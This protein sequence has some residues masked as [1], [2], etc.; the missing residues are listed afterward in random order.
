M[1]GAEIRERFLKYFA[2]KGHKVLPGSSLVPADPTVLLTLA[3]MLQFKPI[4]LGQEKPKYKRVATVQKCVRTIDIEQV[5]KTARH[6]TFF[7]MLGNFSFGDYFKKEAIEYAWELL[8]DEFKLPKEKLLIA[9]YEKDDEAYDLWH[10]TMGVPA[11]KIFRLD[12]ENNFWA[13]GPTGPCGPC[14]EIYY[15]QGADKGCGRPDCAPGCDCDRFLEVWNL[16]FIQY[17]RNEKGELVPLKKKGIDTG[18]GLERIASVMQGVD[19]N[20]DT[21]LFV[22]LIERVRELAKVPEPATASLRIIADHVRAATH[23][24]G[25]GVL[26]G[27][28]GREYV[29]RRL[30]RSAVYHGTLLGIKRAFLYSLAREVIAQMKGAYPGLCRKEKVISDAIRAEEENFLLTLDQG[31]QLYRKEEPKFRQKKFIPGEIAFKL[32]DTYGF[33]IAVTGAIAEASGYKVDYD[34]FDRLMEQQKK[35]ARSA[36]IPEDKKKLAAL[37][38]HKFEATK[39][40]GYEKSS[41]EARVQAV[42]P[43]EKFVILDKT[44]FYGESG[45]QVGDTGVLSVNSHQVRVVDTLATPEGISVHEVEDI[46]GLAERKKVTATIDTSKREA[47]SDHHTATHLLHKALREVLGDHVKQAGSYVGPDKLRFDFS[48]FSGMSAAEIENVELIVNQKIKEKLKVEVLQKSYQDAIKMGAVALFGEKYGDKV[49]VLKIGSY[50]LEL[51]GGTHVKSTGD[52][53]FFKITSES[54]LGAGVRRIEAKAGQAAKAYVL[55][56]VKSLRG[57]IEELIR[58]YRVLQIE[59]ERLGGKKF[60]ETGIF[61][62]EMT[63]LESLNH[64]VDNQDSINV[65]KFLVHLQGRVDWLKERITK[66]EK[67]IRDLRL[68]GATQAAAGYAV[69]L[70]GQVNVLAHKFEAKEQYDMQMLRSVSDTVQ[71]QNKSCVVVLASALPGKLVF[72]VTVTP[73]LIEQGYSAKKISEV[74][75]QVVGGKAGGKDNKVEGGGKDPTR[76]DEALKQVLEFIGRAA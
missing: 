32:H 63:E 10:K 23:L 56:A 62:I 20:F 2:S 39:F 59:K 45:G 58:K 18:M 37:D 27:N 17:N 33:P 9:V 7:E 70:V 72:L 42:F 66:A 34:G 69:E 64:A 53:L 40:V 28:G 21:D 38:L 29:V 3:G 47:T 4:F 5:G 60:T 43:K 30:I 41:D 76:I 22:P 12:E 55:F 46:D 11:E 14:S 19:S 74:F 52:I 24:I 51:C 31:L 44:P 16:V 50:S 71:Q 61:E 65:N 25:D 35:R 1:K 15:D 8:T 57:E 26:P 54:A 67:E 13:V 73:D 6:H 36:G 49:R 68:K 75:T 48:H